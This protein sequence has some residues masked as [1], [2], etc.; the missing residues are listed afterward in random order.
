MKKSHSIHGIK[1]ECK[2][3]TI[4]DKRIRKRL[5]K[6]AEH[7]SRYPDCTIP[8]ACENHA[9]IKG[10]YRMFDNEKVTADG[11]LS[12]HREMT[13]RRIKK[14]DI[15]LLVQDTTSL[16]Y[17]SHR[18]VEGIGAIG[19]NPGSRGI[20]LHSTLALTG[21]GVPLGLMDQKYWTRDIEERG[22][23]HRRKELKT[24]E[25]ES[26]RWIEGLERSTEGIAE[27]TMVVTIADREA[28][29]YDLF[30]RSH[31]LKRDILVRAAGS[32]HISSEEKVLLK[33]MEAC[34]SSGSI[35]VTIPRSADEKKGERNATLEIKF[36]EVEVLP[37]SR[38]KKE[39]GL[40][41]ISL[42]A[43]YANEIECKADEEPIQWLLLTSLPITCVDEAAEKIEWY[44]HRWKIERFHYVLKSGCGV[45]ELQLET[46]DRLQNAIAL[47]SI[48]A[49][50]LLWITYE[51]RLHPDASCT[52]VLKKHE[53]QSL[54]CMANQNPN[55]P[56]EAP[57][58]QEAVRMIARLGGFMG[59]KNDGSPGTKVLWRGLRRLYDIA[60]V[61]LLMNPRIV[62]N[63]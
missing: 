52:V 32:R 31:E 20:L 44:R 13:K 51:N 21:K 58:L 24:E 1:D 9:D 56:K 34:T 27:E 8:Q 14:Q 47:Y 28:D 26:Y 57:S 25:K 30:K 10:A 38:R 18:S 22:K 6:T 49:W 33:R 35:S 50:W 45:E 41:E 19:T 7:L 39:M 16:N 17:T 62:G 37:P 36:C 63:E 42:Y 54:W 29:I 15:V 46:V 5:E 11:I 61:W 4:K 53:W 23:K 2:K 12:G 43:I 40:C 59:R 55:P 3:S 60:S 48:I